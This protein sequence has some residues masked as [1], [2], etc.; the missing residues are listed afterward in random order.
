MLQKKSSTIALYAGIYAFQ[1]SANYGAS[2]IIMGGYSL[3]Q[4][5]FY[6]IENVKN[7]RDGN[8]RKRF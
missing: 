4:P 8:L 3:Y 5:T 6:E 2:M 7:R 1:H